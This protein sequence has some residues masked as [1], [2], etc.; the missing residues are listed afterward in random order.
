MRILI[1][2]LVFLLLSN[3]GPKSEQSGGRSPKPQ[4]ECTVRMDRSSP[5]RAARSG[6]EMWQ[7]CALTE[8]Q[9]L[10]ETSAN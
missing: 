8:E 7:T 5:A 10:E 9:M 6:F 2:P 1:L 3:C 4:R